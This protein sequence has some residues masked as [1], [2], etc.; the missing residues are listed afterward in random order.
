MQ[1]KFIGEV[2]IRHREYQDQ[3]RRL[4]GAWRTEDIKITDGGTDINEELG[5]F[6]TQQGA[7]SRKELGQNCV[8]EN[9]P[10]HQIPEFRAGRCEGVEVSVGDEREETF[11]DAE[12]PE[13]TLERREK[14]KRR[15]VPSPR[16]REG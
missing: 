7:E 2:Y 8:F 9:R 5:S 15:G 16:S 1:P 12:V 4:E 6:R 10:L 11:E 13:R 3:G 14:G